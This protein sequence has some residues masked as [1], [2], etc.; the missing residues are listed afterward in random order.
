[1]T[2]DDTVQATTN[3]EGKEKVKSVGLV[4]GHATHV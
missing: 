4:I 1:M 3:C 2:S